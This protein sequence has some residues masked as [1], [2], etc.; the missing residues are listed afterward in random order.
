M[1]IGLLFI[2]TAP[3]KRK[4]KNEPFISEEYQGTIEWIIVVLVIGY[5][6]S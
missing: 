3:S 2:F 6:L 1:L 4:K 5:F